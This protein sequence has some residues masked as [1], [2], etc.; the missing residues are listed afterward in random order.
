MSILGAESTSW[1][2]ISSPTLGAA[3]DKAAIDLV[4]LGDVG[5]VLEDPGTAIGLSV[6]CLPE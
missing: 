2:S 6:E 4:V 1:T 3:S 5:S